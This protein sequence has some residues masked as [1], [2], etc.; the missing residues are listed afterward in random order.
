VLLQEVAN[1]L[2]LKPSP[3]TDPNR[4]ELALAHQPVDAVAAD[5]EE[6]R[7]APDIEQRLQPRRVVEWSVLSSH[8][9]NKNHRAA[10][11]V[12]TARRTRAVE[13]FR[14]VQEELRPLE[15]QRLAGRQRS[16]LWRRQWLLAAELSEQLGWPEAKEL[17]LEACDGRPLTVC[18][19]HLFRSTAHAVRG[20]T[21]STYRHGDG[22]GLVFLDSTSTRGRHPFACYCPGCSRRATDRNRRARSK[23]LAFEAGLEEVV[24]GYAQDGS[25]VLAWSGECSKCGETFISSRIDARRCDRCRRAHR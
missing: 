4:L 17:Q 20:S 5:P 18:Y 21:D 16:E 9:A 6:R 23:L 13:E 8:V 2:L 22:C 19:G 25:E 11:V 3:A 14:A 12:G 24:V 1:A 7:H 15:G 10:A